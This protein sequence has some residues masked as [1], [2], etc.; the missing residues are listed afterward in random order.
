MPPKRGDYTS[1]IRECLS[2]G[3]AHYDV[4]IVAFMA[5]KIPPELAM[6]NHGRRRYGSLTDQIVSGVRRI[7]HD[8]L[9]SLWRQGTI[10]REEDAEGRRMYRLL[11]QTYLDLVQRI[12]A[13]EKKPEDQS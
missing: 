9:A 1:H 4:E 6:R 13:Q 2:D 12:R 3:K 11:D 8:C 10:G 5:S 7:T